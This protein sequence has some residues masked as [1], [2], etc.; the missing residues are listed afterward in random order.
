MSLLNYAD[1]VLNLSRAV[2]M[3]ENCFR[4]LKD[5]YAI[6]GLFFNAKKVKSWHFAVS[7]DLLVLIHLT[8][9]IMRWSP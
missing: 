4:V 6:T 2:S 9:A 8:F 7:I 1:D 5:E 3:I